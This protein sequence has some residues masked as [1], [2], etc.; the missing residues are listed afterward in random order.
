M[1]ACPSVD[2]TPAVPPDQREQR[3]RRWYVYLHL[4]VSPHQKYA[5][6]PRVVDTCRIKYERLGV[7]LND[8]AATLV[9]S[10]ID[11]NLFAG[12]LDHVTGTGDISIRTVE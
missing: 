1:L 12:T 3:S 2:A 11:Q 5:P 10:T 8:I 4:P 6:D 9:Q 7:F